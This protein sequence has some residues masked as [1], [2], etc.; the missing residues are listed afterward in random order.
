MGGAAG[1]ARR[2]FSQE[3]RDVW[4]LLKMDKE[5]RRRAM[6]GYA[7]QYVRGVVEARS[8]ILLPHLT[9]YVT[10]KSR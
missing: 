5:A 8:K 7:L 6:A 9:R 2:A 1:S 3:K 10:L 4:H